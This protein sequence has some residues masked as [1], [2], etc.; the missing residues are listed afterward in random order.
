MRLR[1]AWI[2]LPLA[3]CGSQPELAWEVSFASEALRPRAIRVQGE[4]RGGGCAGERIFF[5]E[6]TREEMADAPPDL[7]PGVYGFAAEAVDATCTVFA[8]GC[9]E[10]PMPGPN[11]VVTTLVASME[12]PLCSELLCTAGRCDLDAGDPSDAGPRDVGVD[13]RDAGDTDGGMDSGCASDADCG[14]CARCVSGTCAPRADELACPGGVCVAGVCCRGCIQE[15]ACEAGTAPEACGDAGSACVTCTCPTDA[16]VEGAC[17]IGHVVEDVAAGAMS[18]C[19]LVGGRLS[20]FGDDRLGQLAQGEVSVGSAT[21]IASASDLRFD[22]IADGD[23][24]S[25]ALSG[26]QVFAWGDNEDLQLGYGAAG[27]ASPTPMRSGSLAGATAI[28]GGSAGDMSCAL[29]GTRLFCFGQNDYRQ[30][31][32]LATSTV[33]TPT[34]VMGGPWS[35]VGLGH[36]HTCAVTVAG[37]LFCWGRNQDGQLGLGDAA[38]GTTQTTPAQVGTESDWDSV[39]GGDTHTCGI[40]AGA[41][42]C[43]GNNSQGALGDCTPVYRATPTAISDAASY[44]EVRGGTGFTCGLRASGT[45]AC[46]GANGA[47]QLGRGTTTTRALTPAS[48]GTFDDWTAFAVGEAHACAIREGGALYCWGA[49]TLGQLGLGDFT[50]RN[51]P[52]PVCW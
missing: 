10:V 45:L 34:E 52:T 31:A 38:V 39:E 36:H 50:P 47:G 41:V 19:V 27:E 44:A 7:D 17:E 1:L 25:L 46:W 51:T 3:A 21:P 48:V 15:G 18:T 5:S 12:R 35:E 2:L 37:T 14:D 42:H 32:S 40:R 33:G 6:A 16:C 26:G 11:R 30:V 24:H 28:E 20:C 8:A 29:L 13:A 23:D 49:N 22:A 9:T 43:W 4:I